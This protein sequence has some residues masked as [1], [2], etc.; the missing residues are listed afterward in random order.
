MQC[1]NCPLN[2][3]VSDAVLIAALSGSV[4]DVIAYR[5]Y[6]SFENCITASEF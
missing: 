3:V 1:P 2:N 6:G 4:P 5:R